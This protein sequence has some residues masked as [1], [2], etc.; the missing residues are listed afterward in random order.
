MITESKICNF[1]WKAT[2]FNLLSID[3]KYYSLEQLRGPKGTLIMFICN[4]CPY[5]K[6]LCEKITYETK[7]LKKIGVC[8]IAIMSND[9]NQYKEDSYEN[10]KLFAQKY[11]FNFPYLLDS[12]Q[13]TAKNYDAKCTPDFF[14][15]NKELKLQYRGRLDS[16]NK[17]S[18]IQNKVKRD[19]Y[20]A[21][22]N[23]SEIGEGPRTQIP[24]MGC[25]IKWKQ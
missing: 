19:L 18:I 20:L 11:N 14:G 23:I 15:F 9:T 4:H 22:K 24:S 5:V 13:K 21:M 8:S 12:D 7:E 6:S 10:M 16:S 25:S 17:N 1:G 2:D 3:D